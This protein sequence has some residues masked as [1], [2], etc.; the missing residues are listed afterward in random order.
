MLRYAEQIPWNHYFWTVCFDTRTGSLWSAKPSRCP[1]LPATPPPRLTPSC[2]LL[3]YSSLHRSNPALLPVFPQWDVCWSSSAPRW[4]WN[5]CRKKTPTWRWG[6]ATRPLTAG[7]DGRFGSLDEHSLLEILK[8]DVGK[9]HKL[10][11][12]TKHDCEILIFVF[13]LFLCIKNNKLKCVECSFL[14]VKN[15]AVQ[16]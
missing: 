14:Q 3:I 13:I 8:I 11:W 12:L 16:Q 6:V 15:W 7:R 9:N 4:R 10:S 2:F 1:S 5:E